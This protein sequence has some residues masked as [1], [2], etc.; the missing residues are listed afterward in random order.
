MAGNRSKPVPG[1]RKFLALY[2]QDWIVTCGLGLLFYVVGHHISG[3]KRHFSLEDTSL[4]YPYAVHQ[5]VGTHA[6]H[7]ISAVI[8]FIAQVIINL[9]TVRSWVD[10]HHS[11]L[12]LLLSYTITGSITQLLKVAVGRPRPDVI[13]RCQPIPGSVD[14]VYGLST[15]DICTQTVKHIL[16][17]GWRSFPS[18][19][20]SS[21]FAGLGFLTFYLAGKLH[22]FDKRGYAGKIWLV[23]TPLFGAVFV[24]ISRTMDYRHHWH[25]VVTGSALGLILSYFSYRQYYPGLAE[26][27]AHLPH[28]T[29]FEE[30][31]DNGGGADIPVY[32]DAEVNDDAAFGSGEETIGLL[33]RR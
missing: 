29:R 25:D 31:L 28:M 15:V 2:T 14:P 27:D 6:L 24:A 30:L 1:L 33:G 20:S 22:I 3:F 26:A 9:V 17:D 19:H 7:F 32:R 10:F 13:S 18:G 23:F 5:R 16:D 11:T 4:R 8:P 21:S 12:G